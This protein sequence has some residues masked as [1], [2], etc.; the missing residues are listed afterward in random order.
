MDPQPRLAN[1]L[2][3]L[4]MCCALLFCTSGDLLAQG[5]FTKEELEAQGIIVAEPEEQRPES[6]TNRFIL[7]LRGGVAIPTG[8]VLENIGNGTSIGPLVNLEALYA[9]KDWLR[10]GLMF[11]WHQHDIDLWGPKFGT[12]GTY[13]L[14]PTVEVGP[15][16]GMMKE[17]GIAWVLP[18]ASLGMGV[19]F[20]TFSKSN[21]TP[22]ASVSFSDTFALRV[23]G[24]FDFPIASHL[25]INT[26]VAWNRDS[27][28]YKVNGS[29]ADFNASTVNLLVGLRAQF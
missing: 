21:E 29:K 2:R 24:G 18:Y 4:G 9:L 19:N 23:A 22:P 17:R 12:L 28:T 8:K 15:T 27:G 1:V 26:E 25:A 11:E 14:L 7:G 16:L 20:H 6:R 13:S 3:S 10:L 5:T